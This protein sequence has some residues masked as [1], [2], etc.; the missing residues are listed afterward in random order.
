[1]IVVDVIVKVFYWGFEEGWD[2][3]CIDVK[4][5]Y[6]VKVVGD[7][8]KVFDV[9][10]VVVLEVLWIDLIDYF[11]VLLIG[12]WCGFYRCEFCCLSY[13]SCFILW[14]WLVNCGLGIFVL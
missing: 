8:F 2:L 5:F 14:I 13:L 6:V 4:G 12:V 10:V 7:V 9:V 1:M 3:D 11:V